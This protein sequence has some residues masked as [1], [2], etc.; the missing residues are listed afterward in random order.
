M[1]S[2]ASLPSTETGI[3]ASFQDA[4]YDSATLFTADSLIIAA[5]GEVLGTGRDTEDISGAVLT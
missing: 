2:N 1:S 3:V 5:T 4:Q